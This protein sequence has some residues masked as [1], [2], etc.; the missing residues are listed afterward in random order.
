[1]EYI[2]TDSLFGGKC[3]HFFPGMNCH[4]CGKNISVWMDGHSSIFRAAGSG[5]S[6]DK[7]D[8]LFS[9]LGALQ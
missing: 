1:M 9:E 4:R 6:I 8:V 5:C 7:Q 3:Y 2:C